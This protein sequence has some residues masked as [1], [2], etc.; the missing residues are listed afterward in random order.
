MALKLKTGRNH[1]LMQNRIQS[2]PFQIQYNGITGLINFDQNGLRNTF[3]IDVIE[4]QRNLDD[5][6]PY[7]KVAKYQCPSK[8]NYQCQPIESK[9]DKADNMDFIE[10]ARNYTGGEETTTD[11]STR[12]FTV[13]VRIGPPYVQLK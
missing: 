9:D 7:E 4:L 11:I 1:L 10:Y 3:F 8:D 13:Y 5:D 2:N 12:N 6:Y